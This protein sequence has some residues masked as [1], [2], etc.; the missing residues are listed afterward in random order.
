MK[1]KLALLVVASMVMGS[2]PMTAFASTT[3]NMSKVSTVEV[4][5]KFSATIYMEDFKGADTNDDQTVKLTLTG[6]EFTDEQFKNTKV[7]EEYER[8]VKEY[9]TAWSASLKATVADKTTNKNTANGGKGDGDEGK[10]AAAVAL[11]DFLDQNDDALTKIGQT[12]GGEGA[13]VRYTKLSSTQAMAEFKV[14]ADDIQLPIYAEAKEKGEATVTID[15]TNA[16]VTAGTYK[17]A[18][19]SDGATTLTIGGETSITESATKIKTIVIEEVTKGTL[20][21]G[22][23]IKLKLSNGF[24]WGK[25]VPE[26]VTFPGSTGAKVSGWRLDD[27]D[28]T[29]YIKV[30]AKSTEATTLSIMDAEVYFDDDD[31]KVGDKCEVTVS[32]AGTSKE[33]VTVGTASDFGVKFTVADKELPVFYSG[34]YDD[35]VSSLRVTI[36][37]GVENSW[38]DGRKA[39][40]KFPEGIEVMSVNEEKNS[41]FSNATYEI[42]ENEVKITGET[43]TGK[44]ELGLEFELSV[45][46][47]FTGDITATLTGSAIGEDQT[48]TVGT[49][50]F[51]VTVEADINELK[52]DYRNTPA[53][54]IVITE[55][56]AGV[57]TKD[58]RVE[59]YIDGGIDF[60]GTP[61]VE[62]EKGD[63]KIEDVKTSGGHISFKVKTDTQKEAAVI[64]IKGIELNMNRS[65]PAGKYDLVLKQSG[66][67]TEGTVKSGKG[68]VSIDDYENSENDAIIRNYIDTEKSGKGQGTFD[69]DEVTVL[70]GYVTVVTAGRDQDD[71]TFTTKVQVTIGADKMM[72]GTKEIALDVPA[73]I[74]NGYTMLP[75]RAVTEALSG[76]AIVR[77]DD[78]SHTITI[79]FGQRVVSMKVGSDVMVINGVNVTMSGKCEITDS[80]AFLP[81]RDLG[82]ALGLNDSKIN[83]DDATKT[84]TLN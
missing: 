36:K 26:V 33:S 19:V 27:E 17:I 1:K 65:L 29:A 4:D 59:L 63:M 28:Q 40:I 44:L 32:E 16:I 76:S 11:Y 64:R 7:L 48:V 38:I 49:A 52:L 61:E 23:E 39:T 5:D 57:L 51:P 69:V 14:P 81:L 21:Q 41:K 43:E 22:K 8:L 6:A 71:S 9:N 74:S 72:A 42:D 15:P 45:S 68:D 3:N 82:Y 34:R 84:A 18:N 80:R 73:Y 10:K 46:P 83:W 47:E 30:D 66:K 70:E 24:K 25:K 58:G 55:A 56:E 54:D 75:V 35:E 2:L 13:F 20:E 60:D 12:A 50:K 53:S 79:T 67:A 77:W 62:V 31:A 37:E 78:P